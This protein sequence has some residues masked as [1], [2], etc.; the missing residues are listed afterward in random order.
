MYQ[1]PVWL[2]LLDIPAMSILFTWVFLHTRGSV[3]LWIPRPRSAGFSDLYREYAP[4][5]NELANSID[6]RMTPTIHTRAAEGMQGSAAAALVESL[7]RS[8]C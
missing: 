6:I 2:L 1:L 8:G 4:R 3:L 7:S 5:A